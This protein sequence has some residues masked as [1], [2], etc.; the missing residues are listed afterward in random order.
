MALVHPVLGFLG[1]MH[2]FYSLRVF[3]MGVKGPMGLTGSQQLGAAAPA[4][5]TAPTP[6]MQHQ[7]MQDGPGSHTLPSRAQRFLPVRENHLRDFQLS[8]CIKAIINHV[9]SRLKV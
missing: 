4:P 1:Q 9:V 7:A 3:L 6:L 2:S 5:G 8:F